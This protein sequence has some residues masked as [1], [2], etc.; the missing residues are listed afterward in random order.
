VT[1][2]LH[3]LP[4]VYFIFYVISSVVYDLFYVHHLPVVYDIFYMHQL[5]QFSI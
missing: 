2:M 4:V 3:H 1:E 5:K